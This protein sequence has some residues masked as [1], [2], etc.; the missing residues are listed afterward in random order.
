VGNEK[1]D[2]I[3]INPDDFYNLNKFSQW[4]AKARFRAVITAGILTIATFSIGNGGV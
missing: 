1:A 2:Q 3:E 4:Q